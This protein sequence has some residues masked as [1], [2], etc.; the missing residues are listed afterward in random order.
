M[1][2]VYILIFI[3]C[4]SILI[5]IHELGHL[6]AAKLFKVYCF[7]Y[8]IGFGP[9]LFRKK[10][11]NGETYF[12]L[13]AI[14]FGGYVSMYGENASEEGEEQELPDGIEYIPP[15][16]SIA[17]IKKWKRAIILAA[18]VT[19]NAVLALIIFFVAALMPQKSL[20]LHHV[21]VNENSVLYQAGL[22]NEDSI[23]FDYPA[24]LEDGKIDPNDD[25]YIASTLGYYIL[26][27]E[28]LL[29][30]EDSS[31][32]V[33]ATLVSTEDLTFKVRD[34]DSILVYFYLNADGNIS[35]D[36]PV[37][38]KISGVSSLTT[39]IRLSNYDES[40]ERFELSD[41]E[42]EVTR[43]IKD[44][45]MDSLGLKM[46]LITKQ[47]NF[48]Q[49]VGQSFKDFGNSSTL[50]ARSIGGLFIGK[51]WD[52]VGG[53]VAIASQSVNL[54]MN[55]SVT[56]FVQLWAI[57]SVNLAIVNLLPFPG[58][59]GWQLLVLIVEAVA[60]REIPK[61]VKSI[62]S[63]VGLILLFALMAAILIKD[64]IGLI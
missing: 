39:H 13:R 34:Y 18:G 58:L 14:P 53:P 55:Y 25:A 20:Y 5:V 11:K 56:Y 28:S 29:T 17:N 64:I 26:D 49:A 57:I 36:S 51:G 42:Y 62:V 63:F 6:A 33:L 59:D 30:F 23:Y 9:K 22:R 35:F 27:K 1:I 43:D 40:T 47:N 60:H 2:V 41:K 61:K 10:R 52:Q 44:G 12:A 19:L 24:T 54:L 15:E 21:E 31:T 8:S 38:F 48:G 45:Q 50:I 4:L 7:E 3:L 37:N 32:K 46:A 16:R